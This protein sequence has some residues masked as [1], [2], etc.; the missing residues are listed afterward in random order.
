M[1]QLLLAAFLGITLRAQMLTIELRD[2]STEDVR[3]RSAQPV[4]RAALA[5]AAGCIPGSEEDQSRGATHA[6]F[7]CRHAV[8]RSGPRIA[9]SWD[10]AP[11][12]AALAEAGATNLTTCINHPDWPYSDNNQNLPLQSIPRRTAY[13]GAWPLNAGAGPMQIEVK[14]GY[15]ARSAWR[16]GLAALAFVLLFGAAGMLPRGE[17]FLLRH[18]LAALWTFSC[19]AWMGVIL[20]LDGLRMLSLLFGPAGN[21]RWLWAGLVAV[22]PPLAVA[23]VYTRRREPLAA[24]ALRNPATIAVGAFVVTTAIL[25]GGPQVDPFDLKAYAIGAPLFLLA[26]RLRPSG[27][28]PFALERGELPASL[29]S[30]AQK[31]GVAAPKLMLWQAQDNTPAVAAAMVGRRNMILMSTGLLSLCSQREVDAVAAHELAHFVQNRRLM[32]YVYALAVMGILLTAA[33]SEQRLQVWAVVPTML[34]ALVLSAWKRRLEFAADR[35][36]AR[37]TGDPEAMASVLL[38]ISAANQTP[39][40]GGLFREL[41]LSHPWTVKRLARLGVGLETAESSPNGPAYA[42]EF[43]QTN[44]PLALLLNGLATYFQ[45]LL[46]RIWIASLAAG[47]CAWL[48]HASPI[49]SAAVFLIATAVGFFTISTLWFRYIKQLADKVRMKLLEL[50]G[51]GWA[52]AAHC[53]MSPG[54]GNTLFDAGY[55]W[56]VG[57]FKISNSALCY[58]GDRAAFSIPRAAIESIEVGLG[59]LV[60][61]RRSKVLL[62]HLRGGAPESIALR[63]APDGADA[64]SL[65]RLQELL[66]ACVR[67]LGSGAGGEEDCGLISYELANWPAGEL[68]LKRLMN[69]ATFGRYAAISVVP[70]GFVAWI[71]WGF[72]WSP[73]IVVTAAV[74]LVLFWLFIGHAVVRQDKRLVPPGRK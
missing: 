69:L 38:R 33:Y 54:S 28:R 66:D 30:L 43:A 31:A 56:D 52:G 64:A 25:C 70:A 42:I 63:I 34:C 16:L 2:D 13:C 18:S 49:A 3:F 27:N 22:L 21:S 4:P 19:F 1:K 61:W 32:V 39:I 45:F 60:R 10:F 47:V 41:L 53:G 9:A 58:A 55:M 14:A 59:P 7:T 17:G 20:W 68:V 35:F 46:F 15:Q 48:L 5:A 74:A 36:S 8:Q 6:K 29:Q 50:Y 65:R 72:D 62:I 71:L 67:W 37:L 12:G 40:H 44:R 24:R 73:E 57:L 11:L 26:L 23:L 51:P